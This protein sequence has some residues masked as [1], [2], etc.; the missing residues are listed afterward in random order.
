MVREAL[1]RF[2]SDSLVLGFVADEIEEA[3]GD[4]VV[5][6]RVQEWRDGHLSREI[7]L[8]LLWEFENDDLLRIEKFASKS[9]ALDVARCRQAR[10][11]E[12]PRA[13]RP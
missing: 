13:D 3:N 2:D 1:A 4:V 5:V 6:G 9:A 12:R 7:P 10:Y 11:R 8:T